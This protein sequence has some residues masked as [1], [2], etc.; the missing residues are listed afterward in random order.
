MRQSKFFTRTRKELPQDIESI[1]HR[2]LV[3]GDYIDQ[4]GAGIYAMLPLGL[5]VLRRVEGVI[6]K[7]MDALGCQEILMNV[8]QPKALWEETGRWANYTPPLFTVKDQHGRVFAL[9]PTHEEQVTDLVRRR[10]KS[11]RDLPFS[12]YQIQTKFRNE[13]RATGGLL[14]GRE[15]LMKD[16]YSFHA[17]EEDFQNFYGQV[18]EAYSRI[19]KNCGLEV[20]VV[21]ADTGSIGG[22]MSHEFMFLAT[23]GEDIVACCSKCEYAANTELVGDLKICPKCKTA[24]KMEKAIEGSHIFRLGDKYSKV[25][26]ANFVNEK[27]QSRPIIMGCYG[28]GVGRL[29]AV[30]IEAH[31]H[32]RG[33]NWPAAVAPFDAHVVALTPENQAIAGPAEQLVADLE[34][35]GLKVLYDDRVDVSAGIKFVEADLIGVALRIVISEK[36]LAQGGFEVRFEHGQKPTILKGAELLEGLVH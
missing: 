36:S 1:S 22:T 20:R 21:E 28:I 3:K 27:S 30:I 31:H 17:S 19:F 6:R 13:V 34:R 2:L 33:I 29:M 23:T 15:F 9:G 10:V 18:R 26:A 11:Y 16:L 25:M 24:L 7:E 12:V 14:R 5:K 4:I 8:L 35:R 32:E